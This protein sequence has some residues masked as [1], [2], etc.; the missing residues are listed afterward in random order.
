VDL[1]VLDSRDPAARAHRAGLRRLF[2]LALAKETRQLRRSLPGLPAMRLQYATAPIPDDAEPGGR[3]D[4]EDELVALV[5]DR[6]FLAD[7]PD[8]RDAPAFQ[9]ALEAGRG[10]LSAVAGETCALVGEILR[11]HQE[12]RRALPAKVPA[13]WQVSVDDA[14]AQLGRLLYKGFLHREPWERLTQYPRYLRAVALRLGKLPTAAARDRDRLAEL[15]P[16]LDAWLERDAQAR[17][18]HR[19]D[20]RL[21]EIR[22]MLEELR[23]SLF[24]QELRT[25]YPVSA[26]R[27]EKRWRELGL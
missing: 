5:V 11:C 23:V 15:R 3:W 27:I 13:T 6:T 7:R 20:E 16:W 9:A 24:A 22:W 25:A 26:K 14:L 10:R 18:A 4:L 8:I 19:V 21:E 2:M 17:V 1:R 12:A